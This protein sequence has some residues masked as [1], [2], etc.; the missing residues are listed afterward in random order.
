MFY[1]IV[2]RIFRKFI[3]CNKTRYELDSDFPTRHP[4][5]FSHKLHDVAIYMHDP[6]ACGICMTL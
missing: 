5:N 3:C 4:P 2:V 6:I 1:V